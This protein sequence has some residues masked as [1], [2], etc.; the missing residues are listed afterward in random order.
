MENKLNLG[1]GNKKLEGYIGVD[2]F[3]CSGAEVIADINNLPFKNSTISEVLLDNVIEHLLDITLIMKELYRI[4][5]HNGIIKIRTPHFTSFASWKDPTHYHHL[6]FFSIDYFT[7]KAAKHYTN[8]QFELLSKSLNFSGIWNLLG[9]I[10]F[11]ISPKVY[12]K[13]FCFIFRGGTLTFILKTIKEEN[14]E[15]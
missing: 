9:K 15:V 14:S 7:K 11:L 1:C 8:V 12:E 10:I 6:S 4:C 5:K 3:S 13:Y 2:K